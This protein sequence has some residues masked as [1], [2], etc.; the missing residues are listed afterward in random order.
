MGQGVMIH[1]R[2][3]SFCGRERGTHRHHCFPNTKRHR[4]VYGTIIDNDFNLLPACPKCH[5]SHAK[6]PDWA[7]WDEDKFRH[8]A[9]EAGVILPEGT[10]T[11]QEKLKRGA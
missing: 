11:Y 2:L 4:A 7:R 9:K 8:R 6:V 5:T 3:C 10:K 1:Y